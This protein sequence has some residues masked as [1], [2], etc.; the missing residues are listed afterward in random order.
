MKRCVLVLS[1]I[2][3]LL[4]LLKVFL[5]INRERH[6]VDIHDKKCLIQNGM[7]ITEV[8]E[9]LGRKVKPHQVIRFRHRDSTYRHLLEYPPKFGGEIPVNIEYDPFTY[10]IINYPNSNCDD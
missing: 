5:T 1:I 4:F 3:G 6:I 8:Y 9:I 7:P 10:T 2:L